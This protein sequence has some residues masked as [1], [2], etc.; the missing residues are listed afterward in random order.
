MQAS[1][2]MR[3]ATGVQIYT[4]FRDN[5]IID[6]YDACFASMRASKLKHLCSENSEDAISWNVFRSLRQISPAS[7]LYQLSRKALGREDLSKPE[8]TTIELW[9]TVAPPPSLLADGDEGESE[10]DIVLENPNWVWFVEAKY[11]SDISQGTTT[12]PNR[13]QVLRNIDVG[14]YYSG[15]RDFH[16][17]LLCLN[18]KQ[19]PNGIAAVGKW[20]NTETLQSAL[21]HRVDGLKNVKS[22][23]ILYWREIAEVI[24]SARGSLAHRNERTC[25]E[26]ML[27]WM[28]SKRLAE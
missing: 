18:E 5:L 10:I 24:Q 8:H 19:S 21:P 26:T 3:S 23:G 2:S 12:R 27:D 6:R 16:F 7:W 25:A 9:K 11:K 22:I 15:T 20:A 13:D 28:D 17:S 14:S 4:D 1:N